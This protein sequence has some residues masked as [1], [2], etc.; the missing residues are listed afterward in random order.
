MVVRRSGH[1][2][3]SRRRPWTVQAVHTTRVLLWQT[4]AATAHTGTAG[5]PSMLLV[6]C[7]VWSVVTGHSVVV[8][9][10]LSINLTWPTSLLSRRL[11]V[12]IHTQVSTT[13]VCLRLNLTL[14]RPETPLSS[15]RRIGVPHQNK[16]KLYMPKT[17]ERAE[18]QKLNPVARGKDKLCY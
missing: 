2:S 11:A 16:N 3:A 13:V 18:M 14:E 17:A 1:P 5:S 4:K 15:S 8:T 10:T 7:I 6:S 9:V 12:M